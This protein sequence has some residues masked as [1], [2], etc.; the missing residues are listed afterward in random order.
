MIVITISKVIVIHILDYFE[1]D[2]SLLENAFAIL[3]KV[4]QVPVNPKKITLE[5]GKKWS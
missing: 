2:F 3:K 5:K 1:M 4:K